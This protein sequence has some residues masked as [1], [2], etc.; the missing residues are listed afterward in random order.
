MSGILRDLTAA[1]GVVCLVAA[2]LTIA[3]PLGL[4]VAGVGLIAVAVYTAP[5]PKPPAKPPEGSND[6][7]D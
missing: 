3:L 7:S 2:G 1:A 4:V 5:A 6:G